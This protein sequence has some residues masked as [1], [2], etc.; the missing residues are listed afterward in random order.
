M[1]KRDRKW[2]KKHTH[3]SENIKRSMKKDWTKTN[4]TEM[5][6]NE[7]RNNFSTTADA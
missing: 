3:T 1:E 4:A 5:K 7:R 6:W 2:K